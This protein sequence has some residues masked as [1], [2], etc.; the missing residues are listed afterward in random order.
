[1]AV[2]AARK[3]SMTRDTLERAIKKGAGLL[4]DAAQ[5]ETITYEGYA[6][7][8][9]PVVVECLTDNKN[10]TAP[11]MRL[12]FRKGQ[13]G[14]SGSVTWDFA[15]LGAIEAT[16]PDAGVDAEEAAIEAGAQDLE[17]GDEGQTRFFTEPTDLDA[18]N[19]ALTERRWTVTSAALIWRAKNPVKLED[20]AQRAEV[21]AFLAA[22]DDDDDVQRMFVGFAD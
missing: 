6:P 15:R 13:L 12:L 22:I 21:E 3:A 5:F 20:P 17:A 11:N 14:A 8:Q 19:K 7:Y 18:V 4:D 16:P 10:R 2:D 1:M 9:V